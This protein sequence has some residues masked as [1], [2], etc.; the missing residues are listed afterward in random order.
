MT[1][2]HDYN[3]DLDAIMLYDITTKGYSI[4]CPWESLSERERDRYR[5][6]ASEQRAGAA[7]SR[8]SDTPQPR[9]LPGT[10]ELI[11]TRGDA[12]SMVFTANGEDEHEA[13]SRLFAVI[14]P[15]VA[16]L[17]GSRFRL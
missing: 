9:H 7:S 16:A 12:V 6:L 1:P 10:A 8:P 14:D 5:Q 11:I 15:V 4:T 13:L 17:T 2:N 3:E